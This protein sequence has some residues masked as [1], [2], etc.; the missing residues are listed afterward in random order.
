MYLSYGLGV[1][2]AFIGVKLV[3]EALHTNHAGWINNGEPVV[4]SSAT[5]GLLSAATIFHSFQTLNP[6][7]AIQVLSGVGQGG[8]ELLIGFEDLPSMTGDNDFQDVVIGLRVNTD[9]HFLV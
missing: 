1:I 4:L 3:L 7:D 8:R 5:L 2:L 9:D 6:G